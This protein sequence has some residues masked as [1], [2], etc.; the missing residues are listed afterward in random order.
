MPALTTD[1]GRTLAW[2]ETGA[3]LPLLC[4]PGGP[5]CSSRY[6]GA[7][8]ELAAATKVWRRTFETEEQLARD[9]ASFLRDRL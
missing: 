5:G 1:D 3:G 2:R 6:F 8:P 4:H 7:L 9:A